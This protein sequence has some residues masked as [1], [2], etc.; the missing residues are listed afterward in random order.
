[1]HG[2]KRGTPISFEKFEPNRKRRVKNA[3]FI[4]SKSISALTPSLLGWAEL[5]IRERLG[6]LLMELSSH[7]RKHQ[8]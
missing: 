8:Q 5:T 1:M 2:R 6:V 3:W 7:E 4:L